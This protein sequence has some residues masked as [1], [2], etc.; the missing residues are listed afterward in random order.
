MLAA[1]LI[2]A[3]KVNRR[4]RKTLSRVP[5]AA[6]PLAKRYDVSRFCQ[7]ALPQKNVFKFLKNRDFMRCNEKYIC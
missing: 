3:S 2:T 6:H 5:E 1:S 4:N 7:V